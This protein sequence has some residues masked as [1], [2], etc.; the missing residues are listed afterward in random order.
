LEALENG[1]SLYEEVQGRFLHVS[2]MKYAFDPSL[3]VQH[4]ILSAEVLDP[5]DNTFKPLNADQM[6]KV[7]S[8]EFIAIN[9][10]EG[11]TS[12]KDKCELLVDGEQG[13][14]LSTMVRRN[15]LK[16]I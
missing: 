8:N 1:V 15:W 13:I 2:G 5:T 12:F 14:L 3:P 6:Y 4:R 9:G 10:K 16:V 11:F 7:V